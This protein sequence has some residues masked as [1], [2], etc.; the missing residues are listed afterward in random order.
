MTI[1]TRT[2]ESHSFANRLPPVRSKHASL[3]FGVSFIQWR[4]SSFTK[5]G[6]MLFIC[7]NNRNHGSEFTVFHS[8]ELLGEFLSSFNLWSLL[9][10]F[11]F[12]KTSLLVTVLALAW[13][14]D[15]PTELSM[16]IT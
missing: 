10:S 14:V 3:A 11:P 12:P 16:L 4:I 8:T 7:V 13:R 1:P 9:Q 6:F 5:L 2:L 15:I